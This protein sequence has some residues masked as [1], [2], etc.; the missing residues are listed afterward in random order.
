MV[1][2]K[3]TY[4]TLT[5]NGTGALSASAPALQLS[6]W[7]WVSNGSFVVNSVEKVG[8]PKRHAISF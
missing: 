1:W 6:F 8:L 7:S 3:F 5:R 2:L 4:L